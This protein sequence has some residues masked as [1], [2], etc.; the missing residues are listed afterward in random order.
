MLTT[1]LN[2]IVSAFITTADSIA[3]ATVQK[4]AQLNRQRI[5]TAEYINTEAKKIEQASQSELS[6]LKDTAIAEITSCFD[7]ARATVENG[8]AE[9]TN[10]TEFLS[11]KGMIEASGGNLTDFEI[12]SILQ[13]A[14]GNYWALRLLGNATESKTDARKIL[15]E[16]FKTPDPAYYMELFDEEEAFLDG[17]VKSYTGEAMITGADTSSTTAQLLMQG[18]HFSALHDRLEVNPI[19]LTDNDFEA[20]TLS[21]ADRRTLRKSGIV[22]DLTDNGSR[23]R[24]IQAVQEGG[25]LR[26]ILVRTCWKD[27]VKLE[28]EKL[29]EDAQTD[30]QI[31]FG[32]AG[33]EMSRIANGE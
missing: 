28:E 12:S 23:K 20:P 16:K 1:K 30:N 8:V 6:I 31:K 13:N 27:V 19:Y 29:R 21:P 18:D 14:A 17:F 24:V 7:N 5:Y 26:N 32:G 22:L 15:G 25:R 3:T 2:T 4:V 11:V 33:R 9:S 10:T